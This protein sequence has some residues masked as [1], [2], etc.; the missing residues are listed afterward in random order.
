M[1]LTLLALD[2]VSVGAI[3]CDDDSIMLGGSYQNTAGDY[4]DTYIGGDGCDSIVTTTLVVNPTYNTPVAQTICSNDSI[5]LEGAFQNTAGTYMDTLTSVSGCDS[6]ITTTLTV[7]PTASSSATVTICDGD[8]ILLGGSMQTSAGSYMDTLT[9]ANGCDSIITTTLTVNPTFA[10]GASATI[11]DGDSILLG[12]AFQTVGGNYMD[13]L[14]SVNGCDS[15]I[16]TNLK[17][18]STFA[19]SESAVICN[20]DSIMLGG[21]YQ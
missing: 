1:T 17:L 13:T 7:N 16:T 11:C 15:V 8:S 9:A 19:S 10:T 5:L 6:V 14:T 2:S 12:G 4:V 21:A 3:I 20:G 18:D